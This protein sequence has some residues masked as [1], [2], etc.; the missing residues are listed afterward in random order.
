[1]MRSSGCRRPLRPHRRL[2]R[3]QRRTRQRRTRPRMRR[4]RLRPTNKPNSAGL[5]QARVLTRAALARR[6]F[7]RETPTEVIMLVRLRSLCLAAFVSALVFLIAL[8]A[9]A[10]DVTLD[11]DVISGLPIRAIGPAVMGGRIADIAAVRD[12]EKLTIY[13]GSASGGVWRSRDGG[14]T[15]KPIFDKQPTQ[16]IGS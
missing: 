11:S 1:M 2:R 10:Q 7:I 8:P 16:S 13:I 9:T 4:S 12:G 15:F 14:T 3:M 5:V 6:C